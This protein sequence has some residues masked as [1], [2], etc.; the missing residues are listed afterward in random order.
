[1]KTSLPLLALL[2]LAAPLALRAEDKPAALEKKTE[3]KSDPAK[4]EAGWYTDYAAAQKAARKGN[5]PVIMLFTGSDWCGWCIRLENQ[6]LSKED[7]KTWADKRAVLFKADF[8]RKTKQPANLAAQNEK[9]SQK[10][11]IRGFPTIV[12]T[13]AY[14]KVYGETGYQKMSPAEY[15]KHL[16]GIIDSKGRNTGGRK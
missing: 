5:K 8:P 11:G 12:V 13:D 4:D 15:T 6:I 3:G 14:G 9:L 16:D 10:F 1:M 7:F 2:C